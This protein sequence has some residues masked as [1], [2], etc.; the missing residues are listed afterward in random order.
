MLTAP[1]R[2]AL[3]KMAR[4][5][6]EAHFAGQ[7]LPAEPCRGELRARRGAFVSL[8]ERESGEL[9]GCIG[10]IEP[11]G[12][13]I[14]TV[15]GAAVAAATRDPRFTPVAQRDLPS[16]AIHISVL[17]PLRTIRPEQVQVGLHGLLVRYAGRSGLLLPQVAVEHGWD[18]ESFLRM[19]CHKA[20]VPEDSWTK[21]GCELLGFEAEVF[22]D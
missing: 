16:L 10:S 19:T 14:E 9:R 20:G 22:A 8:H 5:A 4:A 17:E 13:L 6:L 1:E 7:G 12:P 15:A 21:P 18:R 3:L 11:Q 2:G